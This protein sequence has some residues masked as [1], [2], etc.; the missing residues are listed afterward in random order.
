MVPSETLNS[1]GFGNLGMTIGYLENVKKAS[2]KAS[3]GTGVEQ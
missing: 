3:S 2:T 1:M